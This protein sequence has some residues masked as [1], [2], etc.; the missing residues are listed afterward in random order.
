LLDFIIEFGL[1]PL[2]QYKVADVRL[3]T[4][5]LPQDKLKFFYKD[6]AALRAQEAKN[7]PIFYDFVEKMIA[8]FDNSQ[9]T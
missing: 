7:K 9:N 3:L 1:N 5:T 4:K 2:L 6:E 8:Y